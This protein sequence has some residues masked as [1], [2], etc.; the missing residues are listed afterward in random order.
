MMKNHWLV[1]SLIALFAWSAE[2][3]EQ[4]LPAHW[5]GDDPK[6]KV[7]IDYAPWD[8]VLRSSVLLS[9]PVNREKAKSEVAYVGTRL[10]NKYKTRTI[11]AGN[12]FHYEQ[13]R[14]KPELNQN[15][16]VIRQSM[17][18]LPSKVALN[19]LTAAEQLAYWLNLYNLVV[20]DEINKVYPEKYL[21]DF[22]TAE[23][24][25]LQRKLLKIEGVELS[26]NDIQHKVLKVKF[27]HDPLVLYGLYQG[28]IGSPSI[29][30]FAYTGENVMRALQANAFDFINSNRGTYPAGNNFLVSSFYQRNADYFPNF[31]QDLR[32][33]L[34]QYLKPAEK[35]S[36]QDADTMYALI[37]D[38][39]VTDI[40]GTRQSFGG[41]SSVSI[42]NDDVPY[43]NRFPPE[44]L[45]YIVELQRRNDEA[46]GT[47]TVK[48]LEPEPPEN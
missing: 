39:M 13:F 35:D 38:W 25:L 36:L 40:Y 9:G 19:T 41:G 46:L 48:D 17:Q 29:R 27:D 30:K 3:R 20:I 12:K 26:L 28:Y 14:K 11:L 22:V 34:E 1:P 44:L 7:V 24:G 15:L 32:A 47:V 6:S 5:F 33:H 18:Q 21:E 2:A 23:D 4:E 45:K 43:L 16:S 31:Q 42:S 8:F 10:T 37:D